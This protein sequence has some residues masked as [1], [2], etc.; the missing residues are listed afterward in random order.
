MAERKRTSN[1]PHIALGAY[2]LLAFAMLAWPGY[3]AFGNRIEPLVLGIPFSLAWI[4]GWVVVSPFVLWA[5]D[6]ATHRDG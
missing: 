5:Y 3:P 2:A 1:L 6:R 4:V